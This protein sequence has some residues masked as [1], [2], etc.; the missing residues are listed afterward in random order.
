MRE[1]Q[2]LR[3]EAKRKFDLRYG[4]L[5]K[6]K[7]KLFKRQDVHEWGVSREL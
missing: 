3:D 1:E 4:Q 6:E 5:I 2:S 7:E